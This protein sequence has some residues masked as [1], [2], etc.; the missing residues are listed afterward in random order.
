MSEFRA[1][2]TSPSYRDTNRY[3]SPA[4][5]LYDWLIVPISKELEAANIKTILFSMD[6]G[7]RTLPI[8]A[9]HDGKQFL[10]EKYSLS[11]IPSFSLTDTRYR[12]Q[13]L[14]NTNTQILAMGQVSLLSNN[15][16]HQYP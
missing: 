16:Y 5:Q 15:P 12:N 2:I 8:A 10:I 4:R 3:L 7:L 11:V 1:Y 13:K 14:Q 6:Q 9:L